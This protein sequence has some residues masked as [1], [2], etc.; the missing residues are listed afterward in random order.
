[1]VLEALHSGRWAISGVNTGARPF[2]RRFAEAFAEYHDV[3]YCVPTASGSTALSVALEA[4]GVC[5]G[6]EVIVPG[7][8]WVACASSVTALGAVPILVDVEPSTLCMAIDAARDAITE[9][10]R[11]IMLVHLYCAC[12]DLDAFLE[13]SRVLG[14][15]L[16]EDCAQAHG[17]SWRGRKVGTHGTVG[18]FSMQHSKVLTAGEGGAVITHDPEVYDRAQQLRADGR[19]YVSEPRAGFMELDEVGSIQGRNRCL[20]EIQAAILLDRLDH[21]DEENRLRERNAERLGA[22]LADRGLA[23][24]LHRHPQVDERTFYH[25]CCRLEPD[26]FGG[27]GSDSVAEALTAELS[28]LVEPVDDPLNRNRLYSP[29]RSPRT[30]SDDAWHRRLD[31][32]RFSLPTADAAR[33]TCITLP[34]AVFLSEEEAIDSVADAFAKVSRLSGSLSRSGS[35]TGV[36]GAL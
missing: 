25:F 30:G 26:A 5:R 2:E 6:D 32:T 9:R 29:L 17:T 22:Q 11:A 23:R 31:P 14:L 13:L 12:A 10:T 16:I 21:L 3:P 24:L 36:E 7:M 8:T 20:S 27:Q 18:T 34:H 35:L 33:E 4:V 1:M 15:P 28:I 19:R